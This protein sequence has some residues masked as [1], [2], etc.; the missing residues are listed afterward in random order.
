MAVQA[1]VTSLQRAVE[2]LQT[3]F[4]CVATVVD[5]HP[6][7]GESVVV[8]LVGDACEDLL[9]WL[10]GVAEAA[11]QADA[12]AQRRDYPALARQL[13]TCSTACDRTV[14]RFVTGLAGVESLS[15]LRDLALDRPG[16]WQSWSWQVQGAIGDTWPQVW[17][18]RS[19]LDGCW[20]ELVERLQ[21]EPVVVHAQVETPRG[22]NH[23]AVSG[24]R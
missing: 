4:R 3:R 21:N 5:D 19:H 13:A 20:Q 17:A 10:A 1:A 23:R 7:A 2:E 14:E 8:D 9:G 16:A 24:G 11:D 12:S 18:L 22:P 6:A 15:R